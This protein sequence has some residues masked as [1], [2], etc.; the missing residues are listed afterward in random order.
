MFRDG[1]YLNPPRFLQWPL[2][3]HE[4]APIACVCRQP[5]AVT[6]HIPKLT[7][8]FRDFP[9]L[10]GKYQRNLARA[11]VLRLS[12]FQMFIYCIIMKNICA[13]VRLCRYFLRL[14]NTPWVHEVA[15][16][17]I[18]GH[19]IFLSAGEHSAWKIP[20]GPIL[21]AFRESVQTQPQ[22]KRFVRMYF[23]FG[24]IRYGGSDT[25]AAM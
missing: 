16:I 14:I 22:S 6:H 3:A 10:Q 21:S 18:S 9:Q 12:P 17:I 24:V 1:L 15:I 8:V 23:T 5:T 4:G 20:L 11:N 13:E 7:E 19:K 25:E 2:T